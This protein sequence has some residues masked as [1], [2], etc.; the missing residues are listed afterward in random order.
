MKPSP[1]SSKVFE[2]FGWYGAAAILSAYALVSFN[3]IPADGWVYQLLNLTGAIGVM[4]I[5]FIKQARQPA[6]LNLVWAL[7][8]L[9]ALISLVA[10]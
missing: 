9:I 4:I 3:A 6:L 5:S 8:A 7:V 10:R 1:R 2:I